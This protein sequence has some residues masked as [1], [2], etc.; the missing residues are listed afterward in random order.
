MCGGGGGGGRVMRSMARM[1]DMLLKET[2]NEVSKQTGSSVH[3]CAAPS[4]AEHQQRPA[5]VCL[6]GRLR[7]P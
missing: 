3:R 4:H 2:A 1:T 5:R 7:P 6:T